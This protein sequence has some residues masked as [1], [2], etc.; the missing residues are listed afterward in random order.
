MEE[1]LRPHSI[2]AGEEEEDWKKSLEGQ[3]ALFL[4]SLAG[5]YHSRNGYHNFSHAVDVLQTVYWMLERMGLVP[6]LWNERKVWKRKSSVKKSVVAKLLGPAECFALLIAAVG[7]DVGHP[8]LSNAFMINGRAPLA[9][10]YSEK[11]V[12]ENFHTVTLLHMLKRFNLGY[13]LDASSSSTT[14][15]KTLMSS[16]LATDMAKHFGFVERLGQVEER[17]GWRDAEEDRL[18]LCSTLMKCADISNPTRPHEISKLWSTALFKEWA[19]QSEFESEYSLP[20]TLPRLERESGEVIGPN[21]IEGEMDGKSRLQQAKGQLGFI[22]LFCKPL[23]ENMGKVIEEFEE[24]VER[25]QEGIVAWESIAS[26]GKTASLKSHSTPRPQRHSPPLDATPRLIQRSASSSPPPFIPPLRTIPSA[27]KTTIIPSVAATVAP[28]SPSF[29]LL[30]SH[31]APEDLLPPSMNVAPSCGGRCGA[32]TAKCFECVQAEKG[33]TAK[34]AG[35]WEIETEEERR[36]WP[37]YPFRPAKKRSSN[38]SLSS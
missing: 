17:G 10:V 25:L 29:P 28:F 32:F 15:K 36:E 13:L 7:H 9:Q 14:F 8:G 19:V 31:T 27:L 20:L 26:G 5:A 4:A 38:T 12:L 1:T 37:P 16:V 34:R 24:L 30:V 35:G 3:I 23:F 2:G 21:G 33:D 22:N 18:L 11:S 6:P